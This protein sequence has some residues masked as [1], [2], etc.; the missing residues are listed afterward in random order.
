MYAY[1]LQNYYQHFDK[2]QVK[3]IFLDALKNNLDA[4]LKD[5]FTFLGVDPEFKVQNTEQKNTY[6]KSKFKFLE[7]VLGKNK[8]FSKMLST[9]MPKSFKKKILNTMYVEGSKD[10]VS[11]EDKIYAY[12]FFKE[13]I[14]DLEKLLNKDLSSWKLS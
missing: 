1:N 7:P 6:K 5:I 10:R 8:S 12:Q 2:S 4:T 3:V 9:V 11:P 13:E 14:T